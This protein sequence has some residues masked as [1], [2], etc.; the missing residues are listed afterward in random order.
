[1]RRVI[2]NDCVLDTSTRTVAAVHRSHLPFITF[3]DIL[4]RFFPLVKFLFYIKSGIFILFRKYREKLLKQ[5]VADDVRH[6]ADE[7]A[8]AVIRVISVVFRDRRMYDLGEHKAVV[9]V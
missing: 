1:M 6:A 7:M 5:T 4:S 2:L 9:I 3:F 8:A